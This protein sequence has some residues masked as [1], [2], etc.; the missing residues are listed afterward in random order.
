MPIGQF[1]GDV[2][3]IRKLIR[4]AQIGMDYDEGLWSCATCRLCENTCPRGVDIVDVALG[5]RSLAFEDGKTPDRI[6]KV[7]WDIYEDG[8][9]WG[10]KKKDR[11]KWANGLDVKDASEG[12]EVLLYVGCEASYD[13]RLHNATKSLVSILRSAGIDFGILGNEELCCGEPLLNAGESGYF[14]ELA[15]N[16]IKAFGNTKARIIVTV[17][18]HC[19]STFKN[20][21]GKFGLN[22]KVMHYTEYLHQLLVDGKISFRKSLEAKVTYHD[23]CVLS[24]MDGVVDQPRELL[25]NIKGV[26]F[27]EMK[28]AGEES[29]CCGGGGDRMFMEF[30]GSRLADFRTRQAEETGADL[31]VTACS[32]CNMNLY[33]SARTNDMKIEVR[34]LAELLKDVV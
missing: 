19:S 21:Y 22:T 27:S 12:V 9:P 18:P 17:S 2:L 15:G 30:K 8:N 25:L 13:K 24:R 26:Q 10:G 1:T 3:N 20:Y 14:E 11:A 23:P 29:I 31:L 32:Y 33:D 34:E 28:N 5:L 6:S 7:L 16:N 4:S